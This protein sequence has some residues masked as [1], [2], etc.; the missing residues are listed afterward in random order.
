VEPARGRGRSDNARALLD[1]ERIL[2]I[3][4]ARSGRSD[5]D[6]FAKVGLAHLSRDLGLSVTEVRNKV[7]E[8]VNAMD[9]SICIK[10]DDVLIDTDAPAGL[11]ERLD[12]A[13]ALLARL[14]LASM[15]C[16]GGI[17]IDF[18]AALEPETKARYRR[19]LDDFLDRAQVVEEPAP[20]ARVVIAAIPTDELTIRLGTDPA[21]RHLRPAGVHIKAWRWYVTG[22]LDGVAIG[23]P[24]LP[25]AD[26]TSAALV[27]D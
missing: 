18:G 4:R 21:D 12:G 27:E 3:L 13:D 19:T 1:A 8:V 11:P 14:E 10:G 5:S 9:P 6:G 16:L 20:T 2:N 22:S 15:E 23:E 17:D 24:G 7:N 25:L 26:V